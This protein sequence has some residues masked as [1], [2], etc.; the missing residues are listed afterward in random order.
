MTDLYVT[1]EKGRNVYYAYNLTIP[2]GSVI[3]TIKY[4]FGTKGHGIA[5]VAKDCLKALGYNDREVNKV[6]YQYV[7]PI[8][9]INGNT[10]ANVFIQNDERNV[11]YVVLITLSGFF[12]LVCNSS[13]PD[14]KKFQHWVYNEVIPALFRGEHMNINLH[15]NGGI[16][17]SIESTREKASISLFR[18]IQEEYELKELISKYAKLRRTTFSMAFQELR[19]TIWSSQ[20]VDIFKLKG[21]GTIYQK[22]ISNGLCD[23]AKG[24]LYLLI[25]Q[26]SSDD[27]IIEEQL[28][29]EIA[30]LS[31]ENIMYKNLVDSDPNYIIENGIPH[32][33]VMKK[34]TEEQAEAIIDYANKHSVD[35]AEAIR[36]LFD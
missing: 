7:T 16:L 8:N 29:D 17:E 25:G 20:K 22:I 28:S 14:A 4:D 33:R 24:T 18:F 36:V 15:N 23:E 5:F 6:V 12:E 34:F 27:T 3:R 9:I 19:K 1:D 11:E 2:S 21:N 31:G 32:K 35:I 30:E 10:E 13:M 26:Y